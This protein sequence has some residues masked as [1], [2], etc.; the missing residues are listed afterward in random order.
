[1][2]KREF[3]QAFNRTAP[4]KVTEAFIL[5]EMEKTRMEEF[6][7]HI[8]SG[9][10]SGGAQWA[11]GNAAAMITFVVSQLQFNFAMQLEGKSNRV[12]V[13]LQCISVF[14]FVRH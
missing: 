12:F 2:D 5:R 1:V 4:A 3:K 10:V 14:S 9:T 13:S 7:N 6:L 11:L 8:Q